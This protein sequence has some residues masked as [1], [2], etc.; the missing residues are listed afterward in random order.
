MT[1]LSQ[2]IIEIDGFHFRAGSKIEEVQVFFGDKI[3]ILKLPVGYKLKLLNQYYISDHVCVYGFNF[4]E[5]GVLT[6]FAFLIEVPP[7]IENH[8][9]GEHAKYKLSM[10]KK[11]LKSMIDSEPH[12]SNDHCVFYKFNTV[13]YCASIHDDR[14]YGLIGGEI[15]VSFC[16]VQRL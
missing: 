4:D 15:I 3:R 5:N 13:D 7:T 1:D 10:A 14:D 8:G 12:T 2:G 9:Y 6:D 16:E 11:W